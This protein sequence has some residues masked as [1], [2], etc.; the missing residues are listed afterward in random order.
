MDAAGDS[1]APAAAPAA[2]AP[3]S[4]RIRFGDAPPPSAAIPAPP[5]SPTAAP[6]R[7]AAPYPPG[8][9]VRTGPPPPSGA[10]PL[11]PPLPPRVPGGSPGNVPAPAVAA[12]AAAAS[13]AGPPSPPPRP[14]MPPIPD[15]A[16]AA[17]LFNGAGKAEIDVRLGRVLD[18]AG[19]TLQASSAFV[20]DSDGLTVAGLR[21]SDA[22]AAVAAPLSGVQ[23][24]I[25]PFVPT[26]PEGGA[27]VELDE[28]QG[29][30][31]VVW[32]AT[33]AGKLA[34]GLVLASPLDRGTTRRLR[35]LVQLAVD[36][37]GSV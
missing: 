10:R 6:A 5:P 16:L 9:P 32:T 22:L 14:A 1:P 23:A 33:D 15:E 20:A 24:T 34:L 12:A 25:S 28:A 11:G 17:Q 21:S 37:K 8:M 19:R 13:A 35:R 4:R 26:G 31:Q 7:G 18:Y 2:A 3:A 29:V 30:L 36:T 27:V